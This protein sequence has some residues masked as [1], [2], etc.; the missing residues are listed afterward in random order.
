MDR[1]TGL[2]KLTTFSAAWSPF[3]P[4]CLA[5]LCACS[6]PCKVGTL[7]ALGNQALIRAQSEAG[8]SVRFLVEIGDCRPGEVPQPA[9]HAELPSGTR[10]EIRVVLDQRRQEIEEGRSAPRAAYGEVGFGTDEPGTVR[11]VLDFQG[12]KREVVVEVVSAPP[13]VFGRSVRAHCVGPIRDEGD[14]VLCQDVDIGGISTVRQFSRGVE[15]ASLPRESRLWRVSDDFMASIDGGIG[16]VGV[17][18]SDWRPEV[19]TTLPLRS[20]E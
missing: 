2:R 3:I 19:T 17:R 5:L 9:A 13:I 15:T 12:E 1:E 20:L 4:V 11:L 16:R 18:L 6:P 8:S 7:S 10:G 14:E